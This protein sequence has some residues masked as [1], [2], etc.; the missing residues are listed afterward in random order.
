MIYTVTI[1]PSLD[2]FS[3]LDDLQR[4][5]INYSNEDK[6]T[7]G[8]R[9]INVSRVL[10]N[11]GLPTLATGFVGGRT[12]AFIEDELDRSDIP[13]DFVHVEGNTRINLNLFVNHMETRILGKGKPI[14]IN[15]VNELMYYIARVREGDFVILGGSIPPGVSDS[16]YD[17]MIEICV[18]NGADFIPILSGPLLKRTLSRAP[19]LIAP[20][21]DELDAMFDTRLTEL[22]EAIPLA[23]SCIDAGV[24]NVIV[25]NG[26]LGSLLVTSNRKVYTVGGPKD[27]II[28]R[29]ST[30]VSLIAGFVGSFMRTHDPV[31]SFHLAQAA[32]NAAYLVKGIPTREEMEREKEKIEV[33]PFA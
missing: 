22:S 7:A 2:F 11:L 1:N 12:G 4:G 25:T 10:R 21:L 3:I 33:L 8:G 9:A 23:F 13:H 27:A 30:K 18:V 28:S 19:I 6:M 17:R 15:K 31:E 32:S 5:R 16:I 20:S 24:K 26:H 14:S 29:T